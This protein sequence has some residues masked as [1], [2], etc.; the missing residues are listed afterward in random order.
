MTE[1]KTGDMLNVQHQTRHS[2]LVHAVA[3]VALVAVALALFWFGSPHV[4]VFSQIHQ[5][6]IA[7]G[8]FQR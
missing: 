6:A 1:S 3:I 2:E 5:I 7:K 4:P 8:G